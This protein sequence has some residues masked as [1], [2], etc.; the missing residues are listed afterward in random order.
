MWNRITIWWWRR[1]K[2]CVFCND[3]ADFWYSG[4]P[5]CCLCA[6][7]IGDIADDEVTEDGSILG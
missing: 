1:Y 4:V 6:S 2:A 7:V 5:V 3:S